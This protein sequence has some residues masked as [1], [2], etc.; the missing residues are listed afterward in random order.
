MSSINTTTF[1]IKSRFRSRRKTT[2][3]STTPTYSQDIMF[4]QHRRL[5][6]P[7]I[8]DNLR[9][10][11]VFGTKAKVGKTVFCTHL[12]NLALRFYPWQTTAW[13]QPIS[14]KDDRLYVQK[15]AP[16]AKAWRPYRELEEKTTFGARFWKRPQYPIVPDDEFTLDYIRNAVRDLD[17]QPGWLFIELPAG[18]DTRTA[19]GRC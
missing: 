13:I 6:Q 14:T 8:P 12:C 18:V 3:I 10:F 19:S 4:Y 1:P 15:Y 2:F 5:V 17:G 16:G 11:F 9:V 7:E